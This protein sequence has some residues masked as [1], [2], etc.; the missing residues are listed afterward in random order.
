LL[1]GLQA[2]NPV[3]SLGNLERVQKH[4]APCFRLWPSHIFWECLA[5]TNSFLTLAPPCFC[6]F[7]FNCIVFQGQLGPSVNVFQFP[8]IECTLLKGP[9]LQGLL[10]GYTVASLGH[11]KRVQKHENLTFLEHF[12]MYLIIFVI[13]S[14]YLVIYR[15]C[16][17]TLCPLIPHRNK[18]GWFSWGVV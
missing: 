17:S 2:K 5:H 16:P 6:S 3:A 7:A 18:I 8:C 9:L 4:L 14:E 13:V 11:L 15:L 12:D 1:Q 10:A